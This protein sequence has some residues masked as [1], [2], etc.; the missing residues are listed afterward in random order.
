MSELRKTLNKQ[1]GFTLIELI[2]VI[3]ILGILAAVA[4]P[5][6]TGVIG[7]AKDAS[8]ESTKKTIQSAVEIYYIDEG[9][10]PSS[11]QD[12]VEGDYLDEMPD[13][14]KL[15][16]TFDINNDGKVTYSANN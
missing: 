6:V 2:V 7:K 12:L 8:V 1:K 4:V 5:R 9:T 3:A 11:V 15:G 16:V 10:Y 13:S 14:E